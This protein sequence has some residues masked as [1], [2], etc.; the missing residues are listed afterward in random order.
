MKK[1]KLSTMVKMQ[2]HSMILSKEFLAAILINS[3]VVCYTLIF[4]ANR[5][6]KLDKV[7]TTTAGEASVIF[8]E[9]IGWSLFSILWPFLVVLPCATSF[10]QEKKD[11]CVGTIVMRDGWDHYLKG[12][13]IASAI[14][15]AIAVG[16]PV[17]LNLISA[18]II[19]PDNLNSV[20]TY[21]GINW[22]NLFSGENRG[23]I[24]AASSFFM[25]R[26]YFMNHFLYYFLYC[27]IL[28][29]FS[30]L[31]AAAVTAFSFRFSKSKIVL[32]IPLYAFV[33]SMM[34]L[35][36]FTFQS[37]L[38]GRNVFCEPS[39]VEYLSAF[40]SRDASPVYF[41]LI[42]VFLILIVIG[43]LNWAKKNPLSMIQG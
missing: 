43:F 4:E 28:A 16:V 13:L 10:I 19:F 8:G 30:G 25:I 17:L 5:T 35:S 11:G 34:M 31:C 14:G 42:C 9:S 3:A 33:S 32:F 6:R 12:K 20:Y 41:L 7:L 38:A 24:S 26:L 23:M 1:Q 37:A 29:A 36:P 15:T 22:V 39:I 18:F 21:Q 27:I 2:L 40:G